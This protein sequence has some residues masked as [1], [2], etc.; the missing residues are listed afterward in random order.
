MW[1]RSHYYLRI[2]YEER[3]ETGKAVAHYKRFLDLYA[4]ADESNS[5]V[6]DAKTRL[7]RLQS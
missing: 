1:A 5:E 4:N 7:A 2:V 3:E 6:R